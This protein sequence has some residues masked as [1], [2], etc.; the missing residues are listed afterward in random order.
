MY[1]TF[2]W[3]E[4]SGGGNY[5]IGDDNGGKKFS[6]AA[7]GGRRD[8]SS[9]CFRLSPTVSS[10]RRPEVHHPRHRCRRLSGN[11]AKVMAPDCRADLA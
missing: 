8:G 4:V 1:I 11:W 7:A 2:Q 10:Q 6:T 9:S 3:L 5:R